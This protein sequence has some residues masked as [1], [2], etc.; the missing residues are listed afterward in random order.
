MSDR[1]LAAEI[2]DRANILLG[3]PYKVG[4][5]PKHELV[6]VALAKL[7]PHLL[8]DVVGQWSNSVTPGRI[9]FET[10]PLEHLLTH[11]SLRSESQF[12]AT[13][14]AHGLIHAMQDS[15]L[16]FEPFNVLGMRLLKFHVKYCA[17]APDVTVT[18]LSILQL[19]ITYALSGESW[20]RR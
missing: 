2:L 10:H 20:S 15:A 14:D 1:S 16:F 7:Y 13:A 4:A 12:F 11:Q 3:L 6:A 8:K 18:A 9:V 5:C 19:S 17:C